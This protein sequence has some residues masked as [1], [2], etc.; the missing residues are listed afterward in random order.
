[1]I[2]ESLIHSFRETL[3]SGG[4]NLLVGSGVTLDSKDG[5][6]KPMPSAEEMRSSFCKITG[7]RPDT[8]L[9]RAYQLLSPE[10]RQALLVTPYVGCSPGP[11]VSRLPRYLWRRLFTFNVDDV[12][13]QTYSGLASPK[14]TISP[15]NYDSPFEPTPGRQNLQVVHLHGWA[16]QPESGFV[17][18]AAE[19]ARQMSSNNAWMHMLAE[20]LATEPFIIAGSSLNEMDLEYYL[21]QRGTATPRR[22]LGPSLLIEPQVD[23]ATRKDC[24][25]YGLTLV[26]AGFGDFMEWVSKTL[27]P[28]PSAADLVIPDIGSVFGDDVDRSLLLRFFADFSLVQ[29]GEQP[30]PSVA[31]GYLYGRHPQWSDLHQ[32]LDLP[33]ADLASVTGAIADGSGLKGGFVLVVDE[34]GAGKS[35]TVMRV[36]HSMASR[37]IPVLELSTL[38][39]LDVPAAAHCFARARQPVMILV[40]GVADHA[41]QVAEVLDHPAVGANVTVLGTDRVYRREFIDIVLS[42]MEYK[43]LNLTP[44]QLD[45]L[46]QLIERYR[47]FGLVGDHRAVAAP[48]EFARRLAS[49]AV[50]IAVCRILKDFRPLD[51]IVNSLWEAADVAHRLPYLAAALAQHCYWSG[52]RHSVLQAI[53]RRT[54]LV[55]DLLHERAP[56]RIAEHPRDREF[57]TPINA[58]VGERVLRRVADQWPDDLFNAFVA[59]ARAIAPYVS[60]PAIRRRSPEARLAGRLFDSDKVVKPW[61]GSRAEAFYD[62]TRRDW[63]WNSRY[64]EQRAL[65]LAS[66][67]LPRALSYA[68]HAVAIELHPF[69]LTTLGK[70]LMLQMES[71]PTSRATLFGEAFDHLTR[72]IEIEAQRT[73][74]TVHPFATLLGGVAKY[75]QLGGALTLQQR[76]NTGQFVTEAN[77]LFPDDPYLDVIL[78]NLETVLRR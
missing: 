72:A 33:R 74:T 27:P 53:M 9:N 50:A 25:R 19:Y 56:L 77:D 16:R 62:Q 57:L 76:E 23:V 30:M 65:L 64:W 54:A 60:I 55:A 29:A 17:F 51:A 58:V 5:A 48:R 49:D 41:E 26:E 73:R 52:I 11:T 69:S 28:A 38:S 42:G 12:I 70:L 66:T 67:D 44:L 43:V 21:S 20:I 13:E 2:P 36:A 63:E 22:G 24:E 75:V 47:R 40:D 37:G 45:D 71:E 34:A 1:M 32:G 59:L 7:A 15:L 78:R 31:P 8:L 3:F 68:R 61:L 46:E 6:G 39:R 10:Q 14:Q 18:S 35:T 4:Y